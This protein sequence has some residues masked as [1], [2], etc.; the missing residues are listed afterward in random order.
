MKIF[1]PM[2]LFLFSA[3]IC[4]A[5]W[6]EVF[7][8]KTTGNSFYVDVDRIKKDNNYTY[9]WVLANFTKPVGASGYLS[10]K[11]R[12]KA[13]C[14]KKKRRKLGVFIYKENNA[15]ELI[16]SFRGFGWQYPTPRTIGHAQLEFACSRAK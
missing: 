10:A 5:N 6:V 9:F 8:S 16:D 13:D 4:S 11:V 7:V 2:I 3:N 1:I 14:K 15:I 12:W